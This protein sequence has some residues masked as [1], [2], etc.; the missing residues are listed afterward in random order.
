MIISLEERRNTAYHESGHALVAK[1]VP[2]A[3]PVHKVTIIPRGMALGLTQQVPL[4][5]RHTYSREFLLGDLAIFFGGRAAEELVLGSITTGAGN[6]IERATKIA[7]QMV[8]EYGMSDSIG[9]RTLGQKQ[10]EVFLGRDWGST[11]DYSDA[12]AFEI[13]HEVRELIDEAHDVALDV[14]TVNRDKLDALAARLIEIETMGREDVISFF[15]DVERREPRAHEERSA[16]LAVSRKA[17]RE[18]DRPAAEPPS[19]PGTLRPKLGGPG[20]SPA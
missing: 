6:D 4:D 12:V 1:L 11:P 16:G 18:R 2:G 13:D 19:T 15:A 9:P 3:D 7:R 20:L 5:D 8:T 10:G 14:L 17:S